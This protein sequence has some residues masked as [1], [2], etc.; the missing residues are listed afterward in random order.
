MLFWKGGN[1]YEALHPETPNAHRQRQ[2]K[3]PVVRY[4]V[5]GSELQPQKGWEHFHQSQ[6][7]AEKAFPE[8]T[9]M[10]SLQEK[11]DTSMS[12]FERFDPVWRIRWA[13]IILKRHLR[14]QTG[15]SLCKWLDGT[16]RRD[17]QRH[18]PDQLRIWD[19]WRERW[20]SLKSYYGKR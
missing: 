20:L 9:P 13:L 17:P 18:G 15:F 6:K 3:V 8:N 19:E 2:D 1:T 5:V 12:F 14:Y 4:P 10:G 11:V 16:R 7:Q